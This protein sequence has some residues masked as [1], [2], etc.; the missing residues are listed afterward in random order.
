MMIAMQNL[1]D[2]VATEAFEG[3]NGDTCRDYGHNWFDYAV[4]PAHKRRPFESIAT[5]GRQ[6]CVLVS[7]KSQVKKQRILDL[8]SNVRLRKR[9]EELAKR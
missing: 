5:V 2:M 7:L 4:I 1:L 3:N 8:A 6:P 9:Q